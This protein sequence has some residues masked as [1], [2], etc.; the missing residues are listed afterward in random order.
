M[1]RLHDP[2]GQYQHLRGSLALSAHGRS[3]RKEMIVKWF[4][5]LKAN[6]TTMHIRWWLL[7]KKIGKIIVQKF[8]FPPSQKNYR[9]A[10]YSG[11]EMI[12]AIT[13]QVYQVIH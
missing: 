12:V 6:L 11:T 13:S 9:A 4:R 7:V 1:K 3:G 10:S 2:N 5:R 8:N